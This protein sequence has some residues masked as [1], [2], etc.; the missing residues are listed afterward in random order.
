M[1]SNERKRLRNRSVMSRLRKLERNY[2]QSL[3]GDKKEE[4][5]VALRG[6]ASALDKAAKAGVVHRATANRKK[7][8]LTNALNRVQ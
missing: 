3:T 4:C 5:V 6:L 8:R 7:S 1:R 2:R